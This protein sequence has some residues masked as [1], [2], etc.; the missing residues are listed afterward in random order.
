MGAYD[1]SKTEESKSY[2][3]NEF[4]GN[5]LEF[6]KIAVSPRH[7]IATEQLNTAP[8]PLIVQP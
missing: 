6:F 8:R 5:G 1:P 2:V 7:R 4:T 3:Q